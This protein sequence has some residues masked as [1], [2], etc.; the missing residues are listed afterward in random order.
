MLKGTPQ[1]RKQP[2]IL[3]QIVLSIFTKFDLLTSRTTTETP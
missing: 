1:L 3:L 2:C